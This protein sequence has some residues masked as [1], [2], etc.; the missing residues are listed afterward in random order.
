MN[1]SHLPIAKIVMNRLYASSVVEQLS[2]TMQLRVTDSVS[3]AER[4]WKKTLS[5]LKLPSGK[6]P[7]GQLSYKDHTLDKDQVGFL[8]KDPSITDDTLAHAR[9]SGPFGN[10][11]SSESREQTIANGAPDS[12][13]PHS[14]K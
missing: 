5:S 6:L 4:W 1:P 14:L 2:S 7:L 8:P 12:D 10:R 9:M 3:S 11:G 13:F